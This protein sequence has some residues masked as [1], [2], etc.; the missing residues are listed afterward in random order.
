MPRT[1]APL[2]RLAPALLGAIA[3]GCDQQTNEFIP[4]PPPTVTVANPDV[5][6]ETIYQEYTGRLESVETVVIRARVRGFLESVDFEEGSD[7]EQGDLLFTIEPEL[8]EANLATAQAQLSNAIAERDLARTTL[9]RVNRAFEG[10]GVSDIEVREAEAALD[11]AEAAV[12]AAQADIASA[13]LDL[14]YTTIVAPLSGRI[15]RKLVSA[16]NLVGADGSTE[17]TTIVVD[18]PIYLY[19]SVSERDL[20]EMLRH[21]GSMGE[22]REQRRD[23]IRV[24]LQLA[25]GSE[26]PLRGR[27]DFTENVVDPTTGTL[28]VRAVFE[29]PDGLLYPGLF[30][31]VL[32][33]F[34]SDEFML[35][36]E[37]AIQRD[38]VGPYAM[39]VDADDVVK[40]RGLVLGAL[41]GDE[42]IV[43][44][45]LQPSDRIIVRGLQRAREGLTVTPAIADQ[46]PAAPQ[47]P[48]AAGAATGQPSGAQPSGGG[49]PG[50]GA[51][52]GGASGGGGD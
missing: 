48:S 30:G 22:T 43:E 17:L 49:T 36:P 45:G 44:S 13:Q 5:R 35:I 28:R 37:I 39:I 14:D 34:R 27:I 2:R 47:A 50:G 12:N 32:I 4:P 25:D 11:Q 19:F 18:D 1:P 9:D 31:R 38:I 15:S 40:R 6:D 26:Y 52:G 23:R 46:Q 20:I 29:N 16:G 33:P 21:A 7:V 10:G 24:R 42:R 41:V 51:S 8:Y 3:A